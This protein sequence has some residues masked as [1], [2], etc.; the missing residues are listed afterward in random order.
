M[1]TLSAQPITPSHPKWEEFFDRLSGPE[2]CD[3]TETSAR[4]TGGIDRPFSRR[5]LASLGFSEREIAAS[6]G[7]FK[8][9]GGYC[10]CEVVMNVGRLG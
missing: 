8:R 1:P 6:L 5:I 7:Y 9:H 2:G 3:F 10:D 4:C